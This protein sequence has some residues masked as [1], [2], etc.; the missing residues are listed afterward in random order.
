MIR[1]I[2]DAI[3]IKGIEICH[4][5]WGIGGIFNSVFKNVHRKGIYMQDC[6]IMESVGAEILMGN[7][8]KLE[9]VT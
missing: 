1:S 2:L 9:I 8:G 7:M 3:R 4:I 5:K 6:S